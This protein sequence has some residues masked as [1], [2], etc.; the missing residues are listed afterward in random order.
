MCSDE[1]RKVINIFNI[2]SFYRVHK[3]EELV[4]ENA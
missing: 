4:K 2:R 3:K 1:M